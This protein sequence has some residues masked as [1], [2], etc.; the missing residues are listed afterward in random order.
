MSPLAHFPG[1]PRYWGDAQIYLNPIVLCF[2]NKE[3]DK[4]LKIEI[5]NPI[6]KKTSSIKASFKED[7]EMRNTLLKENPKDLRIEFY[8]R[9]G[10]T[11]RIIY[12]R[13]CKCVEMP[14]NEVEIQLESWEDKY[15]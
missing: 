1:G 13:E 3:C 7:D 5:P 10:K 11:I 6:D 8:D 15:F 4:L 9:E 14:N 12:M 2:D